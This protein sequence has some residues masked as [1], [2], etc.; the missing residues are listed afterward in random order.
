M[1]SRRLIASVALSVSL[2]WSF[3]GRAADPPAAFECRWCDTP[4][5]ID[6]IGDDEAWKHAQPI[7][8]FYLPWLK[9]PRAATTK[10]KAKL[11]WDRDN[12]YFLAEMED[13]DLF[14]D[15]TEYNGQTWNNDVFELFFR[16]ASDKPGRTE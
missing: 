15:V 5:K 8:Q 3:P 16:P 6:G 11:L 14:A 4:I 10:T 7:D 13:G 2:A 1:L 9:Q 12:L